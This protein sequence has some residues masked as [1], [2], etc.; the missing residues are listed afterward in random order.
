M[1][2]KATSGSIKKNRTFPY[3]INMTLVSALM[4]V[5][6]FSSESVILKVVTLLSI[7]LYL[8]GIYKKHIISWWLGF[9][10]ICILSFSSFMNVVL[11]LSSAYVD[12]YT[13]ITNSI[14]A[15][16]GL[17][18]LRLSWLVKSE[19]QKSTQ[20]EQNRDN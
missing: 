17:F 15:I 5:V 2:D 14:G 6:I 16:G 20:L 9:L 8:I 13:I 11:E 10:Y 3:Q 19:Y 18:I 7:S 4:I 12:D 1:N